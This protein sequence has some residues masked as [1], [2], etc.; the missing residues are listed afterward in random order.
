M[1]DELKCYRC[2]AELTAL[3]PPLSRRDTCPSCRAD[4]RVCLMCTAYDAS[5]VRQCTEDDA[6]DVVEKSRAN[7]CDYFA[8]NPAAHVPG[9][10]TA[11]DRAAAELAALFDDTDAGSASPDGD[12]SVLA[13]AEALFKS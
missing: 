8:P 11:Q 4:L 13:D 3:T 5:A 6:E 12:T 1:S 10:M 7:F 9:Q 2:G